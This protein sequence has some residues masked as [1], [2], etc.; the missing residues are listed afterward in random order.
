[1]ST[2]F[3][4]NRTIWILAVALLLVM[5]V[6]LLWRDYKTS[7][8]IVALRLRLNEA[9]VKIRVA[10]SLQMFGQTFIP[11]F[12]ATDLYE[13]PTIVPHIGEQEMV[14]LLFKASDC[15]SC[16]SAL[17]AIDPTVLD[18]MP[19]IGIAQF[20]TAAEVYKTIKQ[21]AYRFPVFIAKD[22]PFNLTR[23]PYGVLIDKY[24]NIRYLSK[25]DPSRKSVSETIA[26]MKQRGKGG[27]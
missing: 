5:N 4:S 14:V 8:E 9:D 1:M 3:H 23:S 13:I 15:S 25:I 26:E 21:Y 24:K 27:K 18:D 16:L 10:D 19:V 2:V 22:N 7:Q 20:S 6:A 12:E 11:E 17:S